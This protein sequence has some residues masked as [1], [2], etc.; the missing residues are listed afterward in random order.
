[1]SIDKRL[2]EDAARLARVQP[3]AD[4]RARL[5]ASLDAVPPLNIPRK[6]R[7]VR[8]WFMP[9]VA[10]LTLVMIIVILPPLTW[11]ATSPNGPAFLAGDQSNADEAIAPS[12]ENN[13]TRGPV[14]NSDQELENPLD[15]RDSANHDNVAQ[16]LRDLPRGRIGIF[17]G[18][19]LLTGFLCL[20]ELKGRPRLL[21]P[22]LAALVLFS[23]AGLAFLLG[24]I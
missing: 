24:I 17:S 16:A 3:P 22:A 7:P 4:L 2:R 18:L 23:T 19:A 11:T 6:Q 13:T 12:A 15:S 9:M 1:M 21:I 14:S 10:M 8:K 20:V 5:Q